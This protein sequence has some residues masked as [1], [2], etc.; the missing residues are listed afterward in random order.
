M[1]ATLNEPLEG[2]ESFDVLLDLI[3]F[4][5]SIHIRISA[6]IRRS[7]FYESGHFLFKIDMS[8]CRSGQVR[9]FLSLRAIIFYFNNA[10]FPILLFFPV[11]RLESGS[12]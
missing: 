11:V 12:F 7:L 2:V 3:D 1:F 6:S 4:V 10:T 5:F 9:P 8:T